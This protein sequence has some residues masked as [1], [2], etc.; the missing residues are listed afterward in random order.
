MIEV[1][2]WSTYLLHG[3]IHFLKH[4]RRPTCEQKH[5]TNMNTT[6]QIYFI[7]LQPELFNFLIHVPVNKWRGLCEHHSRINETV[8]VNHELNQRLLFMVGTKRLAVN[9]RGLTINL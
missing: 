6:Y 5:L 1:E 3:R 2:A 9:N 4:S 8:V 7:Q